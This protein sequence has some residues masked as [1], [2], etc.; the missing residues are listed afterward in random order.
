VLNLLSPEVMALR[1]FAD[2]QGIQWTV[3]ATRPDW[4]G[5][6]PDELKDGWLTFQSGDSRKRLA[7]IPRDWEEASVTRLQLY[8]AAADPISGPRKSGPRDV[9]RDK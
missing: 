8:C 4:R 3:W 2:A 9:Y 5:G 6:V 7:P 1:V